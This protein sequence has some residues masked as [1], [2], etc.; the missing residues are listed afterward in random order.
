MNVKAY[1]VNRSITAPVVLEC[2]RDRR[3]I[4]TRGK[5]LLRVS[6]EYSFLDLL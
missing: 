2:Q 4:L 6:R 1:I 3:V 5:P